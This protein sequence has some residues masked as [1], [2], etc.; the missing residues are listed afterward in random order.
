[1]FK[2]KAVAAND[3]LFALKVK[4]FLVAAAAIAH[5]NG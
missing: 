2:A 4:W 1:M 5:S 3:W